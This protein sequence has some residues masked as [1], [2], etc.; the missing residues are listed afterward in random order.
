MR[1]RKM[2]RSDITA[3]LQVV[4]NAFGPLHGPE[5]A[6][7]TKDLL[8]DPSALPLLSL[9]AAT[10]DKISGH[11]LFTRAGLDSNAASPATVIL[12]PLAVSPEAQN[13]GVGGRLIRTGLRQLSK[14]G[15]ELVFV[16]GHPEYYPRHGFRPAGVLGFAAPFPIP[17][18]DA[19]AW[20]VQELRPGLIG[21]VNGRVL[22]AE[23]LNQ[24]QHWRE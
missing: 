2:N 9:V 21:S 4:E 19:A 16:L 8:N 14:S 18:Q 5:V 23:A 3:V 24:P 6:G 13:R 17:D 11:I 20:M 22:C 10:A 15:V 12:G 7:L 1:I